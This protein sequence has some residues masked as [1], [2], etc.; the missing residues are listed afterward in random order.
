[1]NATPVRSLQA[2]LLVLINFIVFLEILASS[3]M[4]QHVPA[5]LESDCPVGICW[6]HVQASASRI[7]NPRSSRWDAWDWGSLYTLQSF[8]DSFDCTVVRNAFS[9]WIH[10]IYLYDI[11]WWFPCLICIYA[12]YSDYSVYT[13]IHTPTH[14]HYYNIYS[15]YIYIIYIYILYVLY[16]HMIICIIIIY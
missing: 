2:L 9:T 7:D 3:S 5:F 10:L 8:H 11:V 12:I 15:V 13:Y 1:M 4:F 6:N 16:T 14:I